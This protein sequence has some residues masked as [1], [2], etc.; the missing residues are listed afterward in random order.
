MSAAFIQMRVP[1]ERNQPVA[2]NTYLLRFRA[3]DM[4]R[5]IKP[6]QFF[7]VR[8]PQ[9]SDPLLGRPFALYDTVLDETGTPVGIDFVYL[10]VGKMTSRLSQLR[11]GDEL[12]VWGPLGNGFP[13]LADVEHVGLVAGGIGQTPFLAYARSLRGQR[14]YG[15]AALRKQPARVSIYYG[16]RSADLLAGVADFQA[17]GAAVHIAA[18]DGS[19]GF[20][21]RVTGLLADHER[22]QHLV[23]CGP[24]PML[25]ALADLARAWKVPCHLSLET[26]MACGV[27]ICFTCVTPVRTADG[28][29]YRRVCIDGPVFDAA[30][31]A[32]TE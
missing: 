14:G 17:T 31:L 8:L 26:P 7:M 4:A 25:H 11:P 22:P 13:D 32:W 1:V 19:A 15:D 2:R 6:G 9:G 16:V 23:G 28:W 18:E 24:E 5:S 3:A 27:G 20:H 12:E 21:G 29:D 10:V 30:C